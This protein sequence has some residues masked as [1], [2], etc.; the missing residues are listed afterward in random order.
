MTTKKYIPRPLYFN[1]IEPYIGTGLIKVLTG[2]R[3]VGKSYVL[4]QIIDEI[5]KR[6]NAAKILYINKEDYQFDTLRDYNDL[7]VYIKN[8]ELNG[9]NCYLFIDEVQDIKN[10]EISLRSLLSEGWDIYITGSNASFLSSELATYLS[11]RYI[12]IN[13]HSLSYPEFLEF[14]GFIDSPESLMK[15]IRWG[16]MPYLINLPKEDSIIYEYLRN[17]LDT[18]VLRDIVARFNVR[19]IH[20]LQDLINYLAN[21]V[22]SVMSAKRISEY[23]KSQSINLQPKQIL[24]YL[25]Y[26]ES[27]YFVKR[28]KRTDV[29]GKKIFEIG[30]KFYFED[31]GMR[32]AL[33]SY[34]QKDINK[35]LENLVFHHLTTLG[36]QIYIGKKDDKEIDFVSIKDNERTYIQVAYLIPDEKTH[37]R[38][39]G[40]LLSINDNCRK[41]VISLDETISGKY[42]GVEH[43][44]IRQ[45]LLTY[46]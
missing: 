6:D 20:L 44:S 28:V 5:K 26:L 14:H 43:L 36:S 22:G 30:D 40:N 23:L 8:E 24:E 10:F 19:N 25:I 31:L 3:R 46:Q 7:M 1:R 34:Q 17:V 12:Q 37:Q 29:E 32:H 16:G 39:F 45:F 11:G 38:E 15:Y 35:A 4:L 9:S 21:I 2:Q 42:K 41:I 33:I 18:I 13:I 27:V